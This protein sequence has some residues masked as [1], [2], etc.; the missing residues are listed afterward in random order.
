MQV[1]LQFAEHNI[2]S[3]GSGNDVGGHYSVWQLRQLKFQE[4]KWLAQVTLVSSQA[5]TLTWIRGCYTK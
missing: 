4:A 3:L 1:T 2:I 5:K